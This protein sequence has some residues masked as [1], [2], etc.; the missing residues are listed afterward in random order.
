MGG[1]RVGILKLAQPPFFAFFCT[2][3]AHPHAHPPSLSSQN[4]APH[5]ASPPPFSQ[6]RERLSSDTAATTAVC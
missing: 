4:D 3:Q 1:D 2:L 5:L 6:Q